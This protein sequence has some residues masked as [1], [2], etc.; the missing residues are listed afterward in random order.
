[1]RRWPS[2]LKFQ[3]CRTPKAKR[4]R[5][6]SGRRSSSA[7][8]AGSTRWTRRSRR[9]RSGSFLLQHLNAKE[10]G[11]RAFIQRHLRKPEKTAADR[12][13]VDFLLVQYFALCAPESFYHDEISLADVIRIL[14]P[15]VGDA[16]AR[17]PDWCA[18]LE[19]TL[20]FVK[21]CRSLRDLLESGKLDQARLVKESAGNLVLRSSGAGDA[22]AI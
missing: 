1:M 4:C 12:D 14:Q 18:T 5:K 21:D 7:I 8:C 22:G 3:P 17:T 19:A 9:T 11:L 6:K 20:E 2:N 13:K 16:N 15:V 10:E